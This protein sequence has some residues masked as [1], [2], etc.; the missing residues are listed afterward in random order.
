MVAGTALR[1]AIASMPPIVGLRAII[2]R[3]SATQGERSSTYWTYGLRWSRWI[4]SNLFSACRARYFHGSPE[5]TLRLEMGWV[6]I[7][8]LGIEG[9][10]TNRRKQ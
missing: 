8:S 2:H 1:V 3:F 7:S 6:Y 5:R 10:Q 4:G 9:Q